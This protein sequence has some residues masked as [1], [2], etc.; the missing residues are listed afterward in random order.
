MNL[1]SRTNDP[2]YLTRKGGE[3]LVLLT[4]KDYEGLNETHYLLDNPKNAAMLLEAI[5]DLEN[6]GGQ[7]QELVED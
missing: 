4:K 1:V 7:V 6:G 3:D 2:L 5:V